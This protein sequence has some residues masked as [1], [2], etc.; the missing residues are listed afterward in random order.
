MH[1]TA[2]NTAIAL[3]VLACLILIMTVH[4]KFIESQTKQKELILKRQLSPTAKA[5]K[6][7]WYELIHRAADG[8][9]WRA[10]EIQNSID[11]LKNGEDDTRQF[12]TVEIANGELI[13]NWQELGPSNLAGDIKRVTYSEDKDRI[14]AISAGKTLWKG[15][16][17]GSLWEVVNDDLQFD[18]QILEIVKLE[19]G[20]EL[21]FAS[22]HGKL[23]YS[24]DGNLW[25]EA[26]GLGSNATIKD[27]F[28]MSNQEV[29]IISKPSAN[30]SVGLYK[31]DTS[32]QGLI[33]PKKYVKKFDF[34]TQD[35]N[36]IALA[37]NS[38]KTN[39]YGI[40]YDFED[41]DIYT[42]YWKASQQS[43]IETAKYQTPIAA[44]Y[45]LD[46]A[47]IF[48]SLREIA[49]Q[50]YVKLTRIG[51]FGKV[52]SSESRF[53]DE[54]FG[55]SWQPEADLIEQPW[56]DAYTILDDQKTHITGREQC[57]YS[58]QGSDWQLV[59]KWEDYFEDTE[60]N[61]HIDIMQI[62][63]FKKGNRHF[64]LIATH[65]GIY[66][67]E[68]ITEGVT[69]ICLNGLNNAQFYDVVSIEQDENWI[70]AGSQD[71]GWQRGRIE[72]DDPPIKFN[73]ILS[74]DF[75]H[76]KITDD[77]GA[78]MT[79]PE[80]EVI[81]YNNILTFF[82]EENDGT[83]L[84]NVS[85]KVNRPQDQVWISPLM[86][87]P[88]PAFN[89]TVLI[90]GGS[91]DPNKNGSYLIQLQESN[92]SV[93]AL[94]LNKDFS[95]NDGEI[96][97]IEYNP[98]DKDNWFVATTSGHFFFTKD[99][100]ATW[101]QTSP[102]V[103]GVDSFNELYGTDILVSE[104]TPGTLYV[105]G[106]GYSNPGVLKSTDGGLS[107]TDFSNNL[108]PTTVFELA[109]NEEE[110]L[111]FAATEA[112][113]YVYI[114]AFDKWYN[115][116]GNMAPKQA[117]WSVDFI[118]K[119][120][121]VRFGTY[122][123]GV[124]QFE[125]ESFTSNKNLSN[126]DDQIIIYPNPSSESIRI[127]TEFFGNISHYEVLTLAGNFI[128]GGEITTLQDGSIPVSHLAQG[129]YILRLK[130]KEGYIFKKFVKI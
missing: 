122:G 47:R 18:H 130:N 126:L 9:D 22:R 110:N 87:H 79:Y 35:I 65:G 44:N 45:P 81:Y 97:A 72:S 57:Y 71:Q 54:N 69:N 101:I 53:L 34:F 108:P 89:N 14:Y 2:I 51:R 52:W 99:A 28:V 94:E 88:D 15:K 49:G 120:S 41:R 85:F 92:G 30:A 21:I 95:F 29:F 46:E 25:T 62:K 59:N 115:L 23:M 5:I 83:N 119:I 70:F 116:R 39:L 13:G 17:D 107:F 10:I 86:L 12:S 114:K 127:Q 61:L 6:K 64:T 103:P 33:D 125:I 106:S 60:N 4:P 129:A 128:F 76:I 90:A 117:Y 112:G 78:W 7:E 74:G 36:D 43:F 113:P 66:Y 11:E 42:Y 91:L 24:V 56:F 27:M 32:P 26:A 58:V 8:V 48:V 38:T 19:D 50:S 77:L 118:D 105:A 68:D 75:G 104:K 111:I 40:K 124:W 63:E 82:A 121:T 100:G 20:S 16:L 73:Q 1:R 55:Q 123:R 102:I 67:T 84:P 80:G 109:Q 98:L 31:S 3:L 96:S 37:A 93:E